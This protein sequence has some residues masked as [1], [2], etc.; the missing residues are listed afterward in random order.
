MTSGDLGKSPN[1]FMGCKFRKNSCPKC[2]GEHGLNTCQQF[3]TLYVS[4]KISLLTQTS[5]LSIVSF[6]IIQSQIASLLLP[7]NIVVNATVL[8]LPMFDVHV[9]LVIQV[10]C[11]E[12]VIMEEILML[13]KRGL[14]E[15]EVHLES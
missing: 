11:R 3:K 8:L 1:T 15:L 14:L 9:R 4:C 13:M 10:V 7:V 6:L 2:K 12:K 5:Y